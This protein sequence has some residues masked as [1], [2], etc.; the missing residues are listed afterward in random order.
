MCFYFIIFFILGLFSI[1]E[2]FYFKKKE[3][4]RIFIFFSFILF[5]LSF[6]RWENGADWSYYYSFFKKSNIWFLDSEFEFGF[7][8]INEFV[9]IYFNNF[10]I[11]LFFLGG[12]LF[13][14]QTKAIINFSPY[15][16]TSIFL[17]WSVSFGNIFFVRQTIA[18][19]ILFYS[20]RFIQEKR[21]IP[22]FLLIMLA[23]LFHRSSLIFFFAYWI[24]HLKLRPIT[25][26]LLVL[27][28]LII[29]YL[30]SNLIIHN[31]GN[32]D[33]VLGEKL[34]Y[35]V[36][37]RKETFG[38]KA[39]LNEIAIR[40]FLNRL[41]LLLLFL[42]PFEKQFKS[43]D[44]VLTGYINIYWAGVIICLSMIF[45]SFA[46]VRLSFAYDIFLIII[47]PLLL[48]N[49][50]VAKYKI[51]LYLM[52]FLYAGLRLYTLITRSYYDLFV[53]FNTIF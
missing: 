6:V 47:I 1:L 29:S 13:L 36:S 30:F 52:V 21:I 39:S 38:M 3:S 4:Y 42:L 48:S 34:K 50:S 28:C 41:L 2:V 37:H 23:I 32:L 19:V 17:L 16:I 7:A 44:V 27:I 33:G 35:Y 9:R 43:K 31:L 11:L 12:I 10:S 24:Y 18:T 22:F 20:V 51:C 15:P 5:F 14:F 53:P 49:V 40:A 26:F 46:F 45:I 25:M 8:R